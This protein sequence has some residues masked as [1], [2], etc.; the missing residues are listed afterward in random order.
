ML[1]GLGPAVEVRGGGAGP[2]DAPVEAAAGEHPLDLV[3]EQQQ[4]RDRGGV[5]GLVLARVLDRRLQREEGRLPAIVAAVELLD[6][7]DR[8][9]A[10]RRK[11]EAAV[12]AERLLRGE[13]VGVGLRSVERQ[14]AGARGGVDEDQGVAGA[15]GPHHVDHHPGRGLVVRPG[16]HIGLGVGDRRRSVAGLGL[17]HDRV[18]EERRGG[19]RL[20][21]LLRE[22]AVGQ[23][24]GAV[25]HQPGGGCLPKGGRAAVAERDLVT[26]GQREEIAEPVA[27]AADQ[28]ADGSLTMRGPHHVGLLGE[29]GQRLGA[30]LRRPAAKTAVLGLQLGG[31]LGGGLDGHR[32]DRLLT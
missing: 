6:P 26:V 11:P 18:G 3:G 29:R 1:G 12:G 8:R 9:R 16:D 25:A 28:V 20:G 30:D 21:E 23:V 27:D 22:L 5:V 2:L 17:D 13:V 19:G 31:D 15:L 7:G 32:R 4:G 10:E 24:E 14:A